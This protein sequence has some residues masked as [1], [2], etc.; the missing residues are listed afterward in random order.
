MRGLGGGAR[1]RLGFPME[2]LPTLPPDAHGRTTVAQGHP[3]LR[4]LV[5]PAG[6]GASGGARGTPHF[7]KGAH[8]THTRF[9]ATPRVQVRPP[10][11]GRT[12]F[13]RLRLQLVPFREP[14][15]GLRGLLRRLPRPGPLPR[16][17]GGQTG[18]PRPQSKPA[19]AEGEGVSRYS[20]PS[21]GTSPQRQPSQ[22]PS[23]QRP[24]GWASLPWTRTASASLE[25]TR[26]ACQGLRG[27]AGAG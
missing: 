21:P 25:D 27:L 18:R 2:Q 10:S 12:P 7:R 26:S 20:P 15:S 24:S 14:L 16:Q 19:W 1:K 8:R 5:A 3:T 9:V 23:T 13:P 11:G 22:A 4:G 6:T 17:S